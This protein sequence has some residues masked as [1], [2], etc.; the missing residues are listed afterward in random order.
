MSLAC[1]RNK[2]MTLVPGL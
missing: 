1:K 2:E